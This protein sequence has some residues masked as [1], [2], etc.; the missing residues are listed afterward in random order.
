[1]NYFDHAATTSMSKAA[2]HAFT[3]AATLCYGNESS[4]HDEGMKAKQALEASRAIIA[5]SFEVDDECVIF[6][7]GGTESNQLSIQTLLRDLPPSKTHILCSQLE[8]HSILQHMEELNRNG[9]NIEYMEHTSDGTICL[10]HLQRQIKE[11]TALIILQH[12]NSEIGIL[13]PISAVHELIK[14]KQIRLHVDC[15]QSFGKIDC[16]AIS[17]YAD[18]IAVSSH[19]VQGPKG[20]GA[21]VFPSIH[22]LRPHSSITHE[23]GFRAGT[24]NVPGIYSFSIAVQM[25]QHDLAYIKQLRAIIIEEL[26]SVYPF[27]QCVEGAGANQL[28]HIIC[29]LFPKVQGQYVMMELNKRGYCVSSG[30]ACQSGAKEPSKVLLAIGKDVDEAKSS[31]RISLGMAN[32]REQCRNLVK[33]LS[34]IIETVCIQM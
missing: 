4:L 5:S 15:V 24:V 27:I 30:S 8:H 31:I 23:R 9:Y 7:S 22:T 21:I 6:T 28:P 16:T 18:S 13:Q 10:E 17:S 20:V 29:L 26:R 3:E 2:I 25:M 34:E 32:T 1:M 14:Q 19:K 33:A 12:A 11:T